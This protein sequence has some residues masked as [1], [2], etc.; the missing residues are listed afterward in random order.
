MIKYLCNPLYATM[1]I[2]II[3]II[4]QQYNV[5]CKNNP[6]TYHERFGIISDSHE[7]FDDVMT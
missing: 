1:I 2:I 4:I 7:N 6:E 5:Y 3:Y